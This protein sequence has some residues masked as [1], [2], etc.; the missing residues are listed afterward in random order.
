MDSLEFAIHW[1]GFQ[2][3]W[4]TLVCIVG[5]GGVWAIYLEVR[6]RR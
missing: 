5:A 6:K 4:L 2:I 1:L 3:M